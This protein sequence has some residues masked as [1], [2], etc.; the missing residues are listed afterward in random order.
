MLATAGM[1]SRVGT[2]AIAI[3]QATKAMTT[4]SE[5]SEQYKGYREANVAFQIV[6]VR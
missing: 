5:M 6:E 1:Q 4:A 2:I 3:T